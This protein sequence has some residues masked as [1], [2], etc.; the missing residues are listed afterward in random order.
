M[1]EEPPQAVANRN[2]DYE[3]LISAMRQE[4]LN[5]VSQFNSAS[6]QRTADS[7]LAGHSEKLIEQIDSIQSRFAQFQELFL[8]HQKESAESFKHLDDRQKFYIEHVNDMLKTAS[9]KVGDEV[10]AAVKAEAKHS[11]V[12]AAK[13]DEE[14]SDDD[15]VCAPSVPKGTKYFQIAV[16]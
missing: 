7:S 8:Q 16:F 4:M 5:I 11:D 12:Q 13:T 15:V 14:S 9:A 2:G 3:K 10:K 6:D 1:A